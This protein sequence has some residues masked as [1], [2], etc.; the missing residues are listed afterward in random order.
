MDL[1]SFFKF[2]FKNKDVKGARSILI[3]AT[4]LFVAGLILLP[5]PIVIKVATETEAAQ[6]LPK[7]QGVGVPYLFSFI[8]A[9]LAMKNPDTKISTHGTFVALLGILVNLAAFYTNMVA[10]G[11]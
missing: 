7:L 11:M 5:D 6:V 2:D 3:G 10:R 8:G 4:V 9:F 1:K